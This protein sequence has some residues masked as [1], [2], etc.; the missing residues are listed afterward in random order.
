MPMA[1]QVIT[2]VVTIS[3]FVALVVFA[4]VKLVKRIRSIQLENNMA[5]QPEFYTKVETYE[6]LRM[7][8]NATFMDV[9]TLKDKIKD[10]EK[11]R[12]FVPIRLLAQRE[13]EADA[14]KER[15][16]NAEEQFEK[17]D[18]LCKLQRSELDKMSRK[19]RIKW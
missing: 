3:T 16:M 11:E 19:L 12:I 10:Y 17:Q 5:R 7:L 8:R 9:L 2:T 14:L 18:D 6:E 15:L 13:V 1:L 4:V